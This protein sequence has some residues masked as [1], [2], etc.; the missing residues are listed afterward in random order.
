MLAGD[1]QFTYRE[2]TKMKGKTKI[3]EMPTPAA[4]GIFQTE[5]ALIGFSGNTGDIGRA[6]AWLHDITA[7]VPKLANVEM[8][9]LTDKKIIYQATTLKNW[10]K[11]EKPF[12]AIGSGQ[13]FALA[14]MS[15]GKTPYEAVKIAAEYDL[16]TG[17]GFNKMEM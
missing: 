11:I 13:S 2:T 15:A 3:Y 7:K 16:Y 10:L 9:V 8:L 14:A 12:F 6:M 5:K 17:M 4:N 1:K